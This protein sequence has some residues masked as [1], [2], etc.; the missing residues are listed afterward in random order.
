MRLAVALLCAVVFPVLLHG[1]NPARGF[2]P[3]PDLQAAA[4]FGRLSHDAA[5]RPWTIASTLDSTSASTKNHHR[6]EGKILMVVG[7]ATIIGGAV[8]GGNGSFA[9]IIGG[10]L[11]EGYGYYLYHGGK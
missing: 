3:G 1:Q 10:A 2:A 11:I 6:T 4:A 9:I 5:P 8:Y 7:V